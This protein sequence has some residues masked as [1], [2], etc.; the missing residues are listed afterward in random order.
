MLDQ[1]KDA[2]AQKPPVY[3]VTH[4][5]YVLIRSWLHI[6]LANIRPYLITMSC[7]FV[8]IGAPVWLWK[9]NKS[10]GD[11][12]CL[13]HI[14]CAINNR[15]PV[16]VTTVI[17]VTPELF[18]LMEQGLIANKTIM[19][20]TII[21]SSLP[22]RI[23]Q[24]SLICQFFQIRSDLQNFIQISFEPPMLIVVTVFLSTCPRWQAP[25]SISNVSRAFACL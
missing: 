10:I 23:C 8:L 16:Q 13:I 18:T 7:P 9:S 2:W 12:L 22:D 25:S 20:T 17:T 11:Q 24:P 21:I 1:I 14:S 6:G 19:N 3:Q 15:I 4:N 5:R